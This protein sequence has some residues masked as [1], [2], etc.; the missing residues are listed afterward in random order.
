MRTDNLG[1]PLV[2][3]VTFGDETVADHFSAYWGQRRK[4]L[5]L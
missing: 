5:G 4:W 3:V 1:N 2:R